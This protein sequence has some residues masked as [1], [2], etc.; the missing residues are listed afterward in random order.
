MPD[1]YKTHCIFRLFDWG[2]FTGERQ[3]EALTMEKDLPRQ[4]FLKLKHLWGSDILWDIQTSNKVNRQTFF[5]KVSDTFHNMVMNLMN[6]YDANS[7][8]IFCGHSYGGQK[9]ITFAFDS[10]FPV[11]GLITMGSPIT[12]ISGRFSDWGKIPPHLHF[13]QNFRFKYDWI[14]SCFHNHKNKAFTNFVQCE[15]LS[16][17]NPKTWFILGAHTA[18]WNCSEVHKMIAEK[19]MKTFYSSEI[20]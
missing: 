8:L 18:Y 4:K 5:Y 7:N 20:K 3:I 12:A 10:T 1:I 16:S 17:W 9:A 14:G 19:I 2:E 6:Q 15:H 13:W 11:K